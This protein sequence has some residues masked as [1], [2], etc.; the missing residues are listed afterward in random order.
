MIGPF[1]AENLL[2]EAARASGDLNLRKIGGNN[3]IEFHGKLETLNRL[4]HAQA[5]DG[6]DEFVLDAAVRESGTLPKFVAELVTVEFWKERIFMQVKSAAA[7]CA[8]VRGYLP[9][10]NEVLLANF[11]EMLCFH[12]SAVEAIGDAAVDLVDFCARKIVKLHA[13]LPGLRKTWAAPADVKAKSALTETT[14]EAL[15]RQFDE[16]EFSVCICAIN[17][18]RYLCEHRQFAPLTVRTRLLE[19][20]DVLMILVPLLDASPW[21]RV[22]SGKRERFEDARWIPEIE[23]GPLPKLQVSILLSIYFLTL[24]PDCRSRYDLTSSVRRDNLLRVRRY[25]NESVFDQL[26]P[27]ADLLRA[28]EELSISGQVPSALPGTL[29]AS[30]FTVE[31]IAEARAALEGKSRA[32]LAD[33]AEWQVK[34]VFKE[35]DREELIKL[36][37]TA[38]VIDENNW[39]VP[40]CPVCE[41]IADQRCSGCRRVFYCS[42]D[43]QLSHWQKHKVICS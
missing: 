37:K 5:L 19:T 35:E 28:L 14:A 20:H 17:I 39:E 13:I 27:L 32:E 36:A 18:L 10:H 30:A 2:A 15:Q 24:S 16:A 29:A 6:T 22:C 41:K 12:S 1:E 8:A 42:R 21:S 31:L 11:L 43:C 7:A 26:P 34:N 23:D 40:K 4:A 9:I 25:L 33:I 38:N 3:W